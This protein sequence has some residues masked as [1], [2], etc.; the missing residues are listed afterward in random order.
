MEAFLYILVAV[1][2]LMFILFMLGAAKLAGEADRQSEDI[3]KAL[4]R[5]AKRE[6]EAQESA[7]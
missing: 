3:G 4:K 1:L 7:I 5:A 6:R 2:A